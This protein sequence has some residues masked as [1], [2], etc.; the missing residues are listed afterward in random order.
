MT[1]EAL[2]TTELPTTEEALH[3]TEL[4]TTEE[5]LET[6]ELPTTEEALQT[7]E[8]PTTEEALQTT[9]LPTTEETLQTTELPTTEEAVPLHQVSCSLK[10]M[11]AIT[12]GGVSYPTGIAVN[13]KG[14]IAVTEGNCISIFTR[15]G[16]KR[17]TFSLV[18]HHSHGVAFDS[19][20]NILV[21]DHWSHSIKK[22]TPEGKLLT[23]VGRKGSKILEFDCPTGISFSH[24]YKK[25]YVCDQWNN[26]V[27]VLNE[28]LTFSSSF[29]S[30]GSGDRK[31]D[32]PCSV[33]F[34]NNGNI[35]V[36]D[37]WK[38]CIQVFTPHGRFLRKFGKKG[39]GEGELNYPSSVS[40]DSDDIVYVTERDNHRVSIFTC[41][42]NFIQSF[43][44]EGTR[45]GEFNE[46]RGIAVDKHGL[47][48]VSD[49]FNHRVQ[50]F[51]TNPSLP[52]TALPTTM[53]SSQSEE[54]VEIEHLPYHT[55]I[56]VPKSHH[57]PSSVPSLAVQIEHQS[58]K[59]HTYMGHV[60]KSNTL[61]QLH[62]DIL[63]SSKPL[64][65]IG[66]VSN[67]SGIAVNSRGTFAVAERSCISIFTSSGE[68]FSTFRISSEPC[69]F[70]H[71]CGVVFD[72]AG[73][74]LV[75]DVLSHCIKRFTPEGK[76]LTTVGRKGSKK[77]EF[78]YPAGIGI[79]HSNNKVYVCDPW[80]SR[81]QILNDDL[82]F[83]SSFGSRGSGY[84]QFKLPHDVA[85]DSNGSAYI[86]DS[87]NC[88]IQVFTRE[89]KF[90]RKFGK[91]GSARGELY[92]PSSLS[93]DSNDIVYV[94]E[95]DNHRVSI[96]TCQGK[97][98]QSFGTEGER[99]GE[100]NEP[101]G[102]AVKGLVYVSDMFN[103]R[104]Q[105]FKKDPSLPTTAIPPTMH[106]SMSEEAVD[107]EHQ[108]FHTGIGTYMEHPY[109]GHPYMEHPYMEHPYMEHPYME[110]P[111]MEHPYMEH[112]FME[113]PFIKK[114]YMGY[115]PKPFQQPRQDIPMM[116]KP[117]MPGGVITTKEAIQATD[118]SHPW[119]H[120]RPLGYPQSRRV[121]S[122]SRLGEQYIPPTT[123]EALQTTG[124]PKTKKVSKYL[125]SVSLPCHSPTY[126]CESPMP[127]V[128]QVQEDIPKSLQP[129]VTIGGV[130]YPSGIAVNSRG[131][132][133][134]AEHNCVSIFTSRGE[135]MNTF[136]IS[137]EPVQLSC[138]HPCGVV[139][140][141]AGNILVTDIPSHCIK[142]FTPEGKFL[143]AVGRK[144]TEEFEFSYPAG[145]GI[146]PTSTKLY[147]CDRYNHRIQILNEDLVFSSSF[148][149]RG[150]GERLFT[151][152]RDV[153][154]DSIGY[155]Y[156]VDSVNHCIQVFTPEGEFLRKF[157]KKGSGEGELS[158]P[159]GVCIDSSDVV[160]VTERDNHR[161]SL[162]T[163]EGKFM[164]SFGTEGERPG[165]FNEPCGIAVDTSGLV[166]ISDTN[167][168]R[169]QGFKNL[170][171]S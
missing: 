27:Q 12:I 14:E 50:G 135:K 69:Q 153:A 34:D 123:K 140:D 82:T 42:G 106:S 84:G 154:F 64:L 73:N 58:Y 90:L 62:E 113:H 107:V 138:R 149:S 109:M 103:H 11:P 87:A 46:P 28:D 6:T 136:G 51:K 147:I 77:L 71:P 169:V 155:V 48:Y 10:P 108:L 25:V 47:V 65:T 29:G 30:R 83:S 146:H 96:F 115:V 81:I 105:G 143:T 2:Q 100:F 122:Y 44:T 171:T 52:T 37:S 32:Y 102:I 19:A 139:F 22:F 43:G 15:N 60:S 7:T 23:A 125:S 92:F 9:E 38:C 1:E 59:E 112:P 159:S 166:Y 53:H 165:E 26:R 134:V 157:G 162:F 130:S 67:P 35:Y 150:R 160:Y 156:I 86:A 61:Q 133:A 8:L 68:K 93:I 117:F 95:R 41:Q 131:E 114:P 49:T 120:Y 31:F 45:L 121:L 13:D 126:K 89:G 132:I 127:E 124:L 118:H 79:S 141:S 168:N 116:Y 145:I 54:A 18:L 142:K 21:T 164:Q 98:M 170:I 99:P 16:E 33:T 57:Q 63:E 148:G 104:V 158:L 128:K 97:F 152:P 20:G 129:E 75:T 80:N 17:L 56:G 39:S 94:T 74:I 85:F 167:N 119:M 78:S 40:I 137:S 163:S 101:C 88:R 4:P 66:G 110:H 3:G 72:S 24:K 70:W 161:V 144:G 151:F 36:V 55:G 91:R 5:A 76:L 111:Y